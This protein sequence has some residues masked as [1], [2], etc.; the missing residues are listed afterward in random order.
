MMST[1][2]RGFL[3]N[4]RGAQRVRSGVIDPNADLATDEPLRTDDMHQLVAARPARQ[5][6]AGRA[7]RA[8][9]WRVAPGVMA[10]TSLWC[11]RVDQD[12]DLAAEP[13]LVAC[14]A[15]RLLERQELVQPAAFHV[16][17]D[18]V[19]ELGGRRAGSWRVGRRE[20]L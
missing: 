9:R 1:R 14:P 7:F 20:D 5:R 19:R 8:L 3:R 2:A 10:V 17:R 15:D 18:V 12:V 13:A 4:E 16:R 6:D 11:Q